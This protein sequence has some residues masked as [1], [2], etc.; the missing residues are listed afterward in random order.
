MAKILVIEDSHLLRNDLV[1]LLAMEG[2]EVTAAENGRQGVEIATEFHPDLIICDIMMPE[3]DGYGVLEELRQDPQSA[4]IPFIFMT[5]KTDQS[6]IR[7]GM[8]L[9]A[10]DYLTKPFQTSDLLTTVRA[11]L[12]RRAQLDA[13]AA[14]RLD[15]LRESVITA[16]PHEFRTPLNAV[17]GF[18]EMLMTE[19]QHASPEQIVEWAGYVNRAALRLYQLI[20]NYVTYVRIETLARDPEKLAALQIAQTASPGAFIEASA[21]QQ[22]ENT[23]RENDVILNVHETSAIYIAEQDLAKIIWELTDNAIKFSEPRTPI[24]IS[25]ELVSDFYVLRIR[26]QGHG[27][28]RE[29]IA[30]V[31]AYV[32]FDRWLYEQQGM[33]LGLAIARRLAEL[34]GGSLSIESIPA[35]WTTVR[36]QFRLA[37]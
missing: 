9:G 8:G 19:G 23:A 5:A 35:E 25:T 36:V 32:Q 2:Y 3:L 29:Q 26:N 22:T 18:S 16:L 1:D 21:V 11:R 7:L 17:I 14:R 6:D 31:G 15:E 4:T 30:A 12:E 37:S 24:E 13:H 20:D 28:T 27:M 34:T 33:G 10:D